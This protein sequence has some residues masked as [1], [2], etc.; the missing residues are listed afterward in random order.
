MDLTNTWRYYERDEIDQ[1]GV[2]TPQGRDVGR[3]GMQSCCCLH[4]MPST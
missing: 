3:L 4:A 2:W 1:L